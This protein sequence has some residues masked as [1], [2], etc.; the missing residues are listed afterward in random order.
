MVGGGTTV[1]G[2]GRGDHRSGGKQWEGLSSFGGY[3]EELEVHPQTARARKSFGATE[4][5]IQ[6]WPYFKKGLFGLRAARLCY[7]SST[8]PEGQ[9]LATGPRSR[10]GAAGN[11]GTVKALYTM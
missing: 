3:T 7:S 10:G 2:P 4:G 6:G 11:P 9:C 1:G 8:G 5:R